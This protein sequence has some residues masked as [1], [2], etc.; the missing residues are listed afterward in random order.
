MITIRHLETGAVQ[1]VATLDGIDPEA[2]E[3]L[4]VAEPPAAGGV[5]VNGAGQPVP[6][7]LT[8]LQILGLYT[9]AQHG[10]ARRMLDA[11]FPEE[12]PQAGE[13]IDPDALVQRLVDATLALREPIAVTDAFHQNG[14]AFLRA[15]GVIESDAEAARILAGL[16]PSTS[17]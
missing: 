6:R 1:T 17:F 7:R 12:H 8:G 3:Q 10:R 5:L 15:V 13:L 2:W 9:A 11:R 14:T 4:A 16:P